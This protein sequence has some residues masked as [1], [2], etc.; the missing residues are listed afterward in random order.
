MEISLK[1]KGTKEISLNPETPIEH[2]YLTLIKDGEQYLITR[3]P[4][5]NKLILKQ[6]KEEK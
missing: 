6:I 1:I 2:E 3:E 5:S 4:N